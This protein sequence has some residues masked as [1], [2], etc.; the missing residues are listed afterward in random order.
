MHLSFL[1]IS[2]L[3]IAIIAAALLRFW[4]IGAIPPGF[5]FDE[6][7]EGLEAWRILTDPTYR[8]IFLTGNFGVPPLNAY[9]NAITFWLFQQLGLPPGPTAM[10]ITS[11][12]FGT[13]TVATIY[14]LAIE[15]CWLDSAKEDPNN[16]SNWHALLFAFF[17]A[18][19]LATMR[20]HIH[21]SRMGIEPVIVPLVWVAST[22]FLLRGWRTGFPFE[23]ASCGLFLAAGMYAY[24]GAWILPF[25]MIPVALLLVFD[26]A[27]RSVDE[28]D[29]GQGKGQRN[30]KQIYWTPELQHRYGGL[31]ITVM[32]AIVLVTPLGWFFIQ[33]LDLVFL[34]PAQVAVV[35]ETG[36]PADDSVWS[37]A[38]ATINMFTPLGLPGDLDPRR[39]IPGLPVL[40]LWQVTPF[41]LGL[42]IALRNILRPAYTIPVVGLAGLAL[43]GMVSEYAPHFHRIL[44]VAGPTA[45][46]CGL[47]LNTI[48]HGR[49]KPTQW[50]Q[51]KGA[52][53]FLPR[54]VLPP[55]YSDRQKTKHFR[56]T[57]NWTKWTTIVLL[58]LGTATAKWNYFERWAKQPDLFYAFDVGLWEIGQWIATQSPTTGLYLTPR[59]PDHPTLA[60]AIETVDNAPQPISFDGRAVFPVRESPSV[61]PEAY[62]SIEHEDFRTRLLL[63]GVLP[64]AT[65]EKEIL[66]EYGE[67]YARIYLRPQGSATDR[68]PHHP[69]LEML[70]DGISLIGYDVQPPELQ[71]GQILYLQLHWLI[72]SVPKNNWTVF[73]H[74]LT[75]SADGREELVAGH[76]SPPGGGSLPTVRWQ[77]GWRVLDEYQIPI[78]PE[79]SAGAYRLK[80]GMYHQS[81]EHLPANGQG[82]ILGDVEIRN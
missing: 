9:A 34:R 24:Q 61:Q 31:F 5:H 28:E 77:S 65:V 71:S 10:R 18:A 43:P 4:S 52:S 15:L 67:L 62:I 39:N 35:G 47:G 19:S 40:N 16:Q 11:A 45:I 66:D 23:F 54:N 36:S 38:L 74:L 51:T 44:G 79:L 30:F 22:W 8:P 20:W 60:F 3:L 17:C 81:G 80:I 58:L 68:P 13:L 46:L 6:S 76:D 59:Q 42:L 7:F 64:D 48:W 57:K 75:V 49:L 37:S 55:H 29:A 56:G 2:F 73:T 25:M 27:H 21:F 70:G 33:N 69:H 82:I 50:W 41:Y 78:P 12:F 26:F 32:I 53:L 14:G 72:D 1:L 63:P